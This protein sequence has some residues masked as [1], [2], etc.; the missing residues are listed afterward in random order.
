LG[1][2]FENPNLADSS[3]RAFSLLH[4]Q[5]PFEIAPSIVE[6]VNMFLLTTK[7]AFPRIRD[8]RICFAAVSL[9]FSIV[10]LAVPDTAH[11]YIGPGAGFAFLG[12]FFVFFVTFI[13]ALTA[14]FTWPIRALSR[15]W[16]QR[17]F[18]Q[19]PRKTEKAIVIGF[20]G[21]EPTLVERY[22][23]QGLLPHFS[24]LK[25]QGS[26]RHLRSTLPPLSPVAWSTFQTGVNPGKHSIFDF[27]HRNPKNYLSELS[28]AEIRAGARQLKLGRFLLP[29][30]RPVLRLL[31]RSQPFWKILGDHGVFS[32]ILR[33][34]ITFPPEKFDGMSLSA[35]C[36]P[37]LRGTQGTFSYYTTASK[38][39]E[40]KTGGEFV[41]VRWIDDTIRTWITG[42]QH[43]FRSTPRDLK[44][45]LILRKHNDGIRLQVGREN[46]LL[47][48]GEDSRWI[49]VSF[50]AD[51]FKVRGIVRF[52]LACVEPQL[53]LYMSP[54]QIDPSTPSLP[55]S[56]PNAFA[57][58]LANKQGPY[59]TLGLAEDTWALNEGALDDPAFWKQC[60][61]IH[62]ERETM[63]WD[64]L[65]H[66]RQGLLVCVFDITDRVQ[67]MFWRYEDTSHPSHPATK[68]VGLEDPLLKTYRKADA[69]LG[70]LLDRMD[71]NT[72]LFV[73]SDHGFRSFR[74]CVNLNA[75]LHQNGYLHFRP[76]QERGDWFRGVDWNATR[77]YA[78][79]LGGLYI[80]QK[81]R[82]ALGIV[83]KGEETETLKSEIIS[84]LSSLKDPQTGKRAILDVVDTAKAYHGPYTESAPDLIIGYNAGFRNAWESTVGRTT[85]T[86]FYDN[87]KKW[88]GDHCMLPDM[89]PGV[90]F[91]NRAVAEE[92]PGIGDLAPTL[93]DAFGVT[94]PAY[95]D[96]KV[97]TFKTDAS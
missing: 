25:E 95:M 66:H 9:L 18:Q 23:K 11:A 61:D 78:V 44:A 76:G 62:Q 74:R 80:N 10:S 27:L 73:M 38:A 58:Y 37:D 88:S 51:L 69:F 19:Q 82:E 45:P 26:Y 31:R 92:N 87:V 32:I 56:H 42:P 2:K 91:S 4:R 35:M 36:V 86:V 54:V 3:Y 90:L 85:E 34:P 30:G 93:L 6:R 55:I 7:P 50:R 64:A 5:S 52:R 75:W 8:T 40:E 14:L 89:V 13:L 47:R 48:C 79:G 22:M 94:P 16:R 59:A 97:L 63:F 21:M 39:G 67:H 20:D 43:P 46:C 60:C 29:L 12:S 28:S 53:E 17:R 81:G 57:M 96:G 24:R 49:P 83:R 84:H 77:A 70:N 33:V 71:P 72:L 65:E 15:R 68:P 1:R 41:P